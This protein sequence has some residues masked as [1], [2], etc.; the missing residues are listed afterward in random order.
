MLDFW[1]QRKGSL[2]DLLK[3]ITCL[4]DPPEGN[5]CSGNRNVVLVSKVQ[6]QIPRYDTNNTIAQMK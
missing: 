1:G 4:F 6:V 3:P 5:K 2:G